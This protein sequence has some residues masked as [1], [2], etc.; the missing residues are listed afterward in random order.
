[1]RVSHRY[2]FIFFANPKTGSSSVRQFL[3]PY[4]DEFPAKDYLTRTEDL[5]YYPHMRPIEVREVFV[6]RGLDFDSYT[7]FMLTRNPWERLVSLYRHVLEEEERGEADDS[8]GSFAAWL[9]TVRT[10]GPGGGGEDSVRWRKYGAYDTRHYAGDGDGELMVDR[11]LRLED[12]QLT[13]RPYL[14]S[15]GMDDVYERLISRSNRR[16]NARHYSDYYTDETRN[17]VAEMYADDIETFR[18]RFE[19]RDQ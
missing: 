18:Y 6:S 5:P 17:R 16:G 11:I 8:P 15:L 10:E 14:Y 4:S 13:L 7:R 2:R 19:Y 3:N 9:R 12:L 1:M